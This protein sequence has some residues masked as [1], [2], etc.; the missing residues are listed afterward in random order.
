MKICAIATI[1]NRDLQCLFFNSVSLIYQ[2]KICLWTLIYY[3][4]AEGSFTVK[5]RIW[6]L[7]MSFYCGCW[8]SR[9]AQC[10]ADIC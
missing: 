5:D 8:R 10:Q 7:G 1:Q 6:Q 9:Q 2:D 3:L 4:I